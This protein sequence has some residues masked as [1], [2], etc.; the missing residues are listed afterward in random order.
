MSMDR[1]D[2]LRWLRCDDPQ[3]LHGLWQQADRVRADRVGNA[4]HLRGLV[5]ISN[6]CGRTCHYCGLRAANQA[7]SRYRLTEDFFTRCLKP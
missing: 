1:Q 4:V 6:H 3:Q 5:E 2:I 7:V